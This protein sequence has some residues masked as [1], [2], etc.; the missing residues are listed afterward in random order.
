LDRSLIPAL[1]AGGDAADAGAPLDAAGTDGDASPAT[2]GIQACASDGDCKIADA[3]YGAGHCASGACYFVPCERGACTTSTCDADAGTCGADVPHPFHVATLVLPG[4]TSLGCQFDPNA[5]FAVIFPFAFVGTSDPRAPLLAVRI[6]APTNGAAPV[7]PVLGIDFAPTKLVATGRRLY[8]GGA[9]QGTAAP[10]DLPMAL[11]EV[12]SNPDRGALAAREKLLP[13]PEVDALLS[14][15]ATGQVFVTRVESNPPYPTAILDG[16]PADAGA[17]RL[18]PSTG[19]SM[20]TLLGSSGTRLLASD[21]VGHYVLES[22]AGT[23]VPMGTTLSGVA[24]AASNVAS[25]GM[26]GSLLVLSRTLMG[27]GYLHRRLT[28]LLENA[29]A[30]TLVTNG[31]LELVQTFISDGNIDTA[32]LGSAAM[33]DPTTAIAV[34]T[35][36]DPNQATA[37]A[38]SRATTPPTVLTKRLATVGSW[39]P[40][41]GDRFG[42]AGWGSLGYVLSATAQGTGG[43]IDVYD[44]RCEPP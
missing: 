11:L 1:D 20:A 42:A 2:A 44:T 9:V 38:V 35:L 13:Y 29:T 17:L 15:A 7:T 43:T 16:L 14:P 41:N 34:S 28:W 33:V 26:D 36:V 37:M 18:L 3:C 31:G 4:T 30:D 25:T 8:V 10:Y 5:C 6:D 21:L 22:G 19:V 39:N 40:S 32:T 23:L 27:D 12:P 24:L